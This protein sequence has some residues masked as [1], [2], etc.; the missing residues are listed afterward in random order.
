ML[1]KLQIK[2]TKKLFKSKHEIEE[3]K[4]INK[5]KNIINKNYKFTFN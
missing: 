5:H 3:N 1:F 4:N 2:K